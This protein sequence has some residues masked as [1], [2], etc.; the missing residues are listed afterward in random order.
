MTGKRKFR[1]KT[2]QSDDEAEIVKS[3]Q[4]KPKLVIHE[5]LRTVV[6]SGKKEIIEEIEPTTKQEKP[7]H[8]RIGP[9]K[10]PKYLKVTSRFDYQP[11]VCKDYKE[12]GFCGYG[13]S[14]KFLH[15]RGDY[16]AGW[17]INDVKQ[18]VVEEEEEEV[19]FACFLCRND[20]QNTVITQCMH[21]FCEQCLLNHFKSDLRC[22]I[23]LFNTKGILKPN[24]Q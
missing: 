6:P 14:C 10:A 16:K 4:K 8:L 5:S 20:F 15:D 19:P 11:D 13:D 22:P 3:N 7:K 21:L 17:E 1:K 9:Q 12:T 23:C 18:E 24:G 2:E